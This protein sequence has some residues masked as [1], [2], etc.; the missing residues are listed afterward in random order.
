MSY[1]HQ[2]YGGFYDPVG[3]QSS[4]Q[5]T[6]YTYQTVG[7][8]APQYSGT[9]AA[10]YANSGYQGYD[11]QGHQ[12]YGTINNGASNTNQAA[13][14][15]S[16]LSSGYNQQGSAGRANSFQPHD[17]ASW[18]TTGYPSY[19]PTDVQM[20]NRTQNTNS[21]ATTT[22]TYGQHEGGSG[23]HVPQAYPS[24]RASATTT[25][26]TYQ[27]THNHAG[28]QAQTQPQPPQRYA[29]PLH[30][31][32]AQQQGHSNQQSR[33]SK[34][35]PSPQMAAQQTQQQRQQSASAEPSAVTV[36]PSQVY[37]DRAER[38]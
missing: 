20:S 24:A 38:E 18:S 11:T 32:Q 36:N 37:D 14:A 16:S 33:N 3:S 25:S 29:S 10:S 5:P 15:L 26:Q 13:T 1:N 35:K 9:A 8:T 30:A 4:K 19:T 12:S 27:G 31:M 6:G 28:Q 34:H 17:R 2:Q 21:P 22:S 7:T 23:F